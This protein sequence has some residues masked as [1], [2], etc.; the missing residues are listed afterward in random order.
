MQVLPNGLLCFATGKTLQIKTDS[1]DFIEVVKIK[2]CD[3]EGIP[4]KQQRLIFAGRELE[5][6]RTL[7]Y[8]NIQRKSTLQMVLRLRGMIST[9]TSTDTSHPLIDYLMLSDSERA[10]AAIPMPHLRRRAE[11]QGASV[12]VSFNYDPAPGILDDRVRELLSK[13]LDYMW[14]TAT[15]DPSMRV[16]MRMTV[17]R[18]AFLQLLDEKICREDDSEEEDEDEEKY[19]SE[20]EDEDEERPTASPSSSEVVLRNL[21]KLFEDVSGRGACKI[22][23]RMTRG[24]TNACINFHTDGDYASATVQVA[25]N[26]SA[27]Y[28]G[29][30]LCFFVKK[31]RDEEDE[32]KILERTAG[33][34]TQHKRCVLHAVTNLIAGTRKSLFVVDE[35]NGLGEGDV[36]H[37]GTEHVNSFLGGLLKEVKTAKRALQQVREE[38]REAKQA[39]TEAKEQHELHKAAEEEPM[40]ANLDGVYEISSKDLDRET[41]AISADSFKTVFRARLRKDEPFVGQ[42]GQRVAVMQYVQGTGTV[43]AELAI[44]KQL[45]RHPNLTRLL[46][47]ARGGSGAVTSLVTEFAERGSLDE[48]LSAIEE[49][50]KRARTEVLLTAAIQTLDGMLQLVQ[51]NLVHRDLA[52]CNVLAFDFDP[53]DC[54]RVAVKLSSTS[55]CTQKST[56]SMGNGLPFRW[57]SPEAIERRRWSEKSDVWAFAVAM[58]ELFT[59]GRVPYTF[60]ASDSE[61][62]Q[63]VVAG[64]RLERPTQPTECPEGVHAIMQQCW[65]NRP[66]DRPTFAQI[67]PLLMAEYAKAKEG[68]C[69][70]C[71]QQTMV[72]NLLA[73]VPCGHRC[74]CAEH[75]PRLR[76]QPCPI[77]R[78]NVTDMVRVFD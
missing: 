23:L 48:E 65:A 46:A 51:C 69:C 39:R 77:C 45:G 27:E 41:E 49:R 33:S 47:V 21:E 17:S 32:L 53:Q 24:P 7:C 75:A 28:Q 55:A 56:S 20:E 18:A 70:I 73:L 29:G 5:D 59:H 34:V 13:F 25:L 22:A 66:G 64:G 1:S 71:L 2:I 19:D 9:F 36:I 60:L 38:L 58:W 6:G 16:D 31:E 15:T 40:Q 42:A 12:G 35:M 8:Y 62:A 72:G 3:L 10:S 30:R 43:A 54:K 68:E 11:R 37:A 4:P 44:F 61:V 67:K 74:V 26:D 50:G 57:M 76:G 63:L 78:R 14:A 52:L